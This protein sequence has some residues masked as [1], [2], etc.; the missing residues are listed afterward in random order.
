MLEK[1][2]S[3]HHLACANLNRLAWASRW[4]CQYKVNL[5]AFL[6]INVEQ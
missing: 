6:K 5:E 2:A 4:E 1:S 3:L